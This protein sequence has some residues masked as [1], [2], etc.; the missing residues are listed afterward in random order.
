MN[1]IIYTFIFSFL[2][3]TF[4]ANSLEMITGH[5]KVLEPTYMPNTIS[6]SMTVGTAS[7]PAGTWLKWNKSE[8]NN[9]AVF[10]TLMAALMSGKKVNVYFLDND[11]TCIGQYLHLLSE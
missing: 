1:R 11:T 10:S 5:V 2:L 4:N 6:F 8:E 9:K 7:C 3:V